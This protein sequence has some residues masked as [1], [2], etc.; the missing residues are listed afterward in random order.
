MRIPIAMAALGTT[1]KAMET[2]VFIAEICRERFPD[3]EIL[4]SYFSRMLKDWTKKRRNIELK[5][6]HQVLAELK[7]GPFMGSGSVF[8]LAMRP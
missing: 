1:T 3:H 8:A 6:P 5:H 7:K 4:W 2:Y